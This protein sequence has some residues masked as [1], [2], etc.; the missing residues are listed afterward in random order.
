[1]NRVSSLP[2]FSGPRGAVVA[3]NTMMFGSVSIRLAVASERNTLEA[4]QLR[5]SLM[6]EHDREPLLAHPDAIEL[7]PAQIAAGRVFVA[8]SGGALAGFAVVLSRDDGDADLDGLFVEPA[9]WRTGLGRALVEHVA[10]FARAG[11]AATLHVIGN[12]HAAEFY[13]RCGFSV[14]GSAETR[15]GPALA[16]RR[17]LAPPA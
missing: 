4:L 9:V 7:P 6:N 11:G 15:F 8:E 2:R 1:M 17:S 3:K 10:A 13:Q 14:C 5:A 16:L 12:P